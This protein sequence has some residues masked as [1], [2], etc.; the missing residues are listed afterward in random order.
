MHIP[1]ALKNK[2]ESLANGLSL[3]LLSR[4]SEGL[5]HAYRSSDYK[6]NLNLHLSNNQRLAYLASRFPATY[7]A[8]YQVLLETIKRCGQD[9]IASLLDIGAGPGTAL[10]AAVG[11]SLPLCFATLVEKDPGF[12]ALGR[13]LLKE[14]SPIDARWICQDVTK[15]L[16]VEPHDLVVASYSLN[17][18]SEKARSEMVATLWRLTK[19]IL[20]IIEPGTKPAFELLKKMREH[21]ILNGAHLIAPCPHSGN[22]PLKE[23]DWCHFS[24]RIERSSLHRKT[25]EATLNYEDEKFSYLIF[26]KRKIEPVHARILRH[27]FKG[28]GFVKLQLCSKTG[29]EEKTMTKKNKLHYSYAKHRE[30]GDDFECV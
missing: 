28:K 11:A 29:L 22:C 26:S 17:E 30:W 2:I 3:S 7:G 18:L 16:N 13:Q 10:L 27:P 24:A 1:S 19:K 12:I 8:V 25:K 6:K 21:L 14:I 15:E 9:P 5:T 20:I 23:N 4:E